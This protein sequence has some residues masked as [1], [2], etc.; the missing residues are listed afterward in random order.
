M[1]N[2]KPFYKIIY[3]ALI[4]IYIDTLYIYKTQNNNNAY[5][6][7]QLNAMILISKQQT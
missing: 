1:Q 3:E 2:K 5:I 4:D 7:I 6:Q